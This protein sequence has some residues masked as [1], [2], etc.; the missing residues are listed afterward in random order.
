MPDEPSTPSVTVDPRIARVV[1]GDRAAAQSLLTE[2]LPRVRNLVRYLVRGDHVV[3]DITQHVLVEL[4]RSLSGFRHDGS[5]H[6]W[7]HRITVRVTLRQAVRQR[8]ERAQQAEIGVELYAV[9]DNALAPDEYL[10]RRDV[11]ALLDCLPEEQRHVVVLHHVVGLS[12]PELAAELAIPF[13]TARSR[14][15]LGL[16]KLRQGLGVTE[17]KP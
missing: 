1:A 9:R 14:L 12:V 10:R 4:L 6:A 3:D 13:E 16:A 2:L 5:L 11:V 15:R 8:R 7:V 17:A